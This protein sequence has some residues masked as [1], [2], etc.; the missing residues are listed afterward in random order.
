M[1]ALLQEKL[2]KRANALGRRVNVGLLGF[3]TTNRAALDILL[4]LEDV[5]SITVR[6]KGLRKSDFPDTVSVV[7]TERAFLDL[8][9]D[10]LIP[11]PSVRR[12]ALVIEPYTEYVTDTDLL[13][14]SRPKELFLVSG[15]DGKSTT[16]TLASL[17]LKERLPSLFTGGNLGVPLWQADHTSPFLL[18]TSSFTLRYSLPKGGRALLTNVTPNHLDWH[19]SLAEYEATKLGLIYAASEP[20]LNL[21]DAISEKA[22]RDL[23]A[24]CLLSTNPETVGELKKYK[25]E[26]TVTSNGTGLLLDGE[27]IVRIAEIRRNEPHNVTN[28]ALAIAMSIGY[29]DVAHVREVARSF[30]GLSY[31]AEEFDVDGVK[32]VSSSIDTTPARAVT[33]LMGLGRRVRLILGGRG[34]GLPLSPMR[35]ALIKYAERIAVYGDIGEEMR[36][37]LESDAPLANIPHRTFKHFSEAIDYA[38]DGA[39]ENDTVLLS[40]AATSYGEFTSYKERAEYFESYVKMGKS[41]DKSENKPP[42]I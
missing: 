6:Q 25:T 2:A 27:E 18:E 19:D 8:D 40:P 3:G 10:I 24:F 14:A 37:F 12:E 4:S 33:T 5:A 21:G 38:T 36:A 17:L 28:L 39:T 29:A 32:Y 42:K 34:K 23:F 15:S 31:R 1:K 11:S 35:D 13:F 16:T 9:E 30:S 26:H 7:S 22:A 41:K 20:I